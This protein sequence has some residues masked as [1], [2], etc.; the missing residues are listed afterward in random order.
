MDQFEFDDATETRFVIGTVP[1]L[2]KKQKT[3][4]SRNA[5]QH[6]NMVLHQEDESTQLGK[7]EIEIVDLE[8]P[9]YDFD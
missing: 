2:Y 1:N 8:Y 5:S 9:E 7:V 6:A 3:L 4:D